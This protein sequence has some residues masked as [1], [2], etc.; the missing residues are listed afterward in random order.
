MGKTRIYETAPGSGQFFIVD[1]IRGDGVGGFGRPV[2]AETMDYALLQDATP[3]Q[4]S[5]HSWHVS[6]ANYLVRAYQNPEDTI[7]DEVRVCGC[8]A[9]QE[10][11]ARGGASAEG[12][13]TSIRPATYDYGVFLLPGNDLPTIA[14]DREF[15]AVYGR[16][17]YKKIY[18]PAKGKKCV[19]YQYDC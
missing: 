11:A 15:E 1:A 6:P 19:D 18:V 13:D 12:V 10:I 16:K 3:A 2:I 9:R 14:P 5:Y 17:V 7:V 4:F 8:G